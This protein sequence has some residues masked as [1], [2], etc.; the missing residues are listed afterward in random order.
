MAKTGS[1][2]RAL[3][4]R[5][6]S[7]PV[8]MLLISFAL[9]GC[10]TLDSLLEVEIPGQLT[11]QG[12]FIP[13]MAETVVLSAVAEI[14]CGYSVLVAA[15]SGRE[16]AWWR[17]SALYGGWNQYGESRASSTGTCGPG[18]NSFYMGFQGGRAMGEQI[19]ELLGEWTDTQV[20][21][22]EQ[23]MAITATYV[24]LTY[25]IMGEVFCETAADQGPLMTP[26]ETLAKG[27]EWI[28][29]ALV[30]LQS[31]GDFEF[32]SATPS[33]TQLARLIRARI[34]FATFDNAGASQDAAAIEPGFVAWVTRDASPNSRRNAFY[35]HHTID[36]H[37]S[38]AG[39]QPDKQG[40]GWPGGVW[41]FTGYRD[42]RIDAQ[43]RAEV[44]GFPVTGVGTPDP[45]VPVQRRGV[46]MGNDS[47]TPMWDQLKYT[48]YDSD[49]PLA[50]WAEAQL[51]LAEIE[52]GQAAIARINALRDVHDLPHYNVANPTAQQVENAIIEERRREFFLENRF[53]ATKL[54]EDLYFPHG[55][56]LAEPESRGLNGRTTC[57]LMPTNEYENNPNIDIPTDGDGDLLLDEP[58]PLQEP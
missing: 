23:L 17:T 35:W 4:G 48:G 12:V 1:W 14:E 24:G 36:N 7:L 19:Y 16:D 34:R 54:R 18:A 47:R 6:S 53:W 33:L 37:G 45:R 51:I 57:Q 32:R 56:G 40:A 28:D 13:A 26:E 55:V 42:L 44:D 39:A 29:Q 11:T 46:H 9:V 41:P 38:I 58:W 50:R 31:T 25:Q 27:E 22:R 3:S 5:A 52:G 20:P 49:I 2:R 43:G 8:S 21:E 15:G 10:D 30:H